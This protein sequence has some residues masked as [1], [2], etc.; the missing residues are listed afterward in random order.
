MTTIAPARPICE[1]CETA[2]ATE[3]LVRDRPAKQG[4]THRACTLACASCGDRLSLTIAR[5]E[6]LTAMYRLAINP[7]IPASQEA[8]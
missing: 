3:L 2:P 6:D 1:W 5:V 8:C 4:G 7:L